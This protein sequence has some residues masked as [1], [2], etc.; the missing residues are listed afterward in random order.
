MRFS[1]FAHNGTVTVSTAAGCGWSAVSNDPWI[2]L[3][4]GGNGTG[5]GAVKYSISALPGR[6]T[7]RSG[8]LT[9]AGKTV[10]VTQSR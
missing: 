10:T 6:L 9:V 5:N 3:V 7:Q 1:E 8:T 4:N 2:T